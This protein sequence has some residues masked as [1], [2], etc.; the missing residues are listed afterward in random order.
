[1]RLLKQFF[2]IVLFCWIC[3]PLQAVEELPIADQITNAEEELNNLESQT[4]GFLQQILKETKPHQKLADFS[5]ELATRTT[6]MSAATS[7]APLSTKIQQRREEVKGNGRLSPEIRAKIEIQIA[8][9]EKRT[10]AL[11]RRASELQKKL[12]TLEKACDQWIVD[13]NELRKSDEK[14]AQEYLRKEI[15]DTLSAIPDRQ[16]A[17]IGY[18]KPQSAPSPAADPDRS[19]QSAVSGSIVR[20]AIPLP[21]LK[22]GVNL[23]SV[24]NAI[25]RV[26]SV[27]PDSLADAAGVKV[28]DIIIM[29]DRRVINRL[30]DVSRA[31]Q[32]VASGDTLLVKVVRNGSRPLTLQTSVP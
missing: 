7:Y 24:V 14:E 18:K 30:D 1:M 31:M 29:I 15:S 12:T 11:R 6:A 17:T 19:T 8:E 10:E 5:A 16:S 28:G 20:K 3:P 13:Y 9:M 27:A 2:L 32:E 22:L 23:P 26:L 21:A 25:P 4:N